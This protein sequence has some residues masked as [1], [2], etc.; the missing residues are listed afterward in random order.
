MQEEIGP[1]SEPIEGQAA[2]L[3]TILMYI[4]NKMV[5]ST[6]PWELR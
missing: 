4:G 3:I 5:D 6:F 2:L 1:Q